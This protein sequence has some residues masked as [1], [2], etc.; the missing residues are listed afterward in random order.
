MFGLNSSVCS[1]LDTTYRVKVNTRTSSDNVEYDGTVTYLGDTCTAT[2]FTSVRCITP[3]GPAELY[4]RVNRSHVA[5]EWNWKWKDSRFSNF[6]MM[7]KQ[8]TVIVSCPPQF[9]EKQPEVTDGEDHESWRVRVKA[10]T[11]KIDKCLVIPFSLG[12]NKNRE[13]NCSL[14]GDPPDLLL[15]VIVNKKDVG[16]GGHWALSFHNERGSS[17]TLYLRLCVTVWVNGNLQCSLLWGSWG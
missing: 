17:D 6:T 15:T 1:Q 11:A 9:I 13:V 8:L 16:R 5:V 3:T 7:R 4:R 12:E 2:P 14:T 10:H